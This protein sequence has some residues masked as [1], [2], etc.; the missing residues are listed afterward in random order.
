MGCKTLKEALFW[1]YAN[2]AMAH[3]AL[4]HGLSSY[5]IQSFAI[6]SRLYSGLMSRRMSI[7]TLYDDECARL[8][9][10]R[11]C[12]YCGASGTLSRDH[13]VSRKLGGSDSA[14]NLVYAC[15]ACNSSKNDRDLL[16][17]Y[18]ARGGFPPLLV[19]RRY[20]KLLIT[21]CEEH[22]LMDLD[23]KDVHGLAM[24]FQINLLPLDFPQPS[25]LR[26]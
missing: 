17:W 12:V 8:K 23:L 4:E 22:D 6:R 11:V 25:E 26:F 1:S 16:A 24:P 13:L 21:F 9:L 19:L 10:D 2:L 14:D 20:L 3:H 7:T 15:R 5:S 18:A